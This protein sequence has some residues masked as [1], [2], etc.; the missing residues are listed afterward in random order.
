MSRGNFKIICCS[1]FRSGGEGA[2]PLAEQVAQHSK[3]RALSKG[4]IVQID[5]EKSGEIRRGNAAENVGF[6]NKWKGF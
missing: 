5:E 1:N 4:W 2:A 6:G 3:I